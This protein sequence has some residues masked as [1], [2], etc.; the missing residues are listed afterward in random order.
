MQSRPAIVEVAAEVVG[1]RLPQARVES[2]NAEPTTDSEGNTAVRITIVLAPDTARS[3]TGDDA[4]DLLVA[5]QQALQAAGEDRLPIVQY[6]T[7]QE[8]AL[9]HGDEELEVRP[10]RRRR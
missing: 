9:D 8:L 5:I 7:S 4:L 1:K 2:V 3:L 10:R 6:T